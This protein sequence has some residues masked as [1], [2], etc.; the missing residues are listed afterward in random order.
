MTKIF[1]EVGDLV[2]CT[3]EKILGTTVFVK[4][5]EFGLIGVI[6]TYEISP[7]RIRNIRDYVVIN[8]KIICLILRVDKEREH[9]DL[10]LRRVSQKDQRELLNKYG[11]EKAMAAII[12]S[13]AK[14]KKDEIIKSIKK[15]YRFISEFLQEAVENPEIL[16]KFDLEKYSEKLLEIMRERLKTKNVK[17]KAKFSLSSLSS[18]GASLIKKALDINEKGIEIFYLSAPLYSINIES[19]NFKEANR[20]LAAI[21]EK[22]SEFSKKNNLKFEVLKE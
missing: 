20:K 19:T 7:G 2:L 4:L 15:E 16:K 1:P 14:D 3:V 21:I 8:K 12:E 13:V 5:E 10:S 9:I 6:G 11:K 17:I 22:I 18:N